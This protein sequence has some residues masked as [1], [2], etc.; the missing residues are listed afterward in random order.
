MGTARQR[1]SHIDL[2]PG[3]RTRVQDEGAGDVLVLVHGTPL[4]T[5]AWD[6]LVPLLRERHRVVRYDVRGHGTAR[7][8]T[9]PESF[10]PLSEDMATLLDEL[11]VRRAHVVGH[12]WG[13]MIAQRFALDHPDRLNRLSLVCTR[14]SPY[15]PFHTAAMNMRASGRVDP[16][17]SLQRWFSPAALAQ[18]HGLAQQVR[19]WLQE[20]PLSGW[21]DAL[22]L[23]ATF[24]V[25]RGLPRVSVPVDVICAELDQ[26]ATPDHM[27]KICAALP[28]GRWTLLDAA[29]HLVP[30]EQPDRV[31]EA[32][33]DG[34]AVGPF[35]RA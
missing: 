17:P 33:L 20:A 7:S 8:V 11:D 26:V 2:A 3:Y 31:A 15:P 18:P 19:G 22:D 23:I 10:A 16:E 4:D 9:V 21:A 5:R 28:H 24:D 12:S 34:R 32:I 35:R 25:L 6:P 29:R 14:S 1:D 13:G 30:L 27:S